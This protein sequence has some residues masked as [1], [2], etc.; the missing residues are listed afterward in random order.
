MAFKLSLVADVRQWLK[1]TQ[2][3]E[4]SI[5]DIADSLDDLAKETKADSDKA[6]DTLARDFKNA[7]DKVK[8]ESKQTGKKLGDNMKHGTKEAGEG[9]DD[10]KD[11]ANQSAKEAAA[12]FS[13]EFEDVSDYI[14][15]VLAQALAGFGPVGAAA[16]LAAAAGIGM[17]VSYL[18]N[19][20]EEAHAA[21]DR[22][23]DLSN[24]IKE[25]GG[26]MSLVDLTDRISE[27]L[28]KIID[29]KDWW[30]V[31]QT[32]DVTGAE[33]LLKLSQ[34][35]N[36]SLEDRQNIMR[37]EAGDVEASRRAWEMWNARLQEA[38]RTNQQF[39]DS[40]GNVHNSNQ[41][42]ID[43]LTK[44][45]DSQKQATAET[46]RGQ[47]AAKL[48]AEADDQQAKALQAAKEANDDFKNSLKDNATVLDEGLDKFKN[49]AGKID[50]AKILQEQA[51]RRKQNKII[52]KF[53]AEAELSDKAKANF[54]KFSPEEQ[55]QLAQDWN[56]GGKSRKKVKMVL[57]GDVSWEKTKV[58]EPAPINQPVQVDPNVKG[59]EEARNNAQAAMAA[60]PVVIQSRVDPPAMPAI[61]ATEPVVYKTKVDDSALPGM[62]TQARSKGQ[63][64]ADS[65]KIEYKTKLNTDGLQAAVNRAAAS[66]RTPT[67]YVNVKARKEV[68]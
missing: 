7:F 62:V 55:L 10:L 19:A 25:A 45:R 47:E 46:L 3:V 50:Y 60:N 63:R 38:W 51:N 61:P 13:G 35:Y 18:Q 44:N 32:G 42:L 5:D 20:E 23:I 66:I 16:G 58:P 26:D 52:L 53:D 14:Q 21:T 64:T 34:K 30:E 59:T 57:E 41:T 31:W 24:A 56:K 12:S 36:L 27:N 33:N 17:L 6:A 22:V 65:K 11:E 8:T 67:I 1:G 2:D 4:K 28:D 68:P 40:E 49:K 43:D 54:R 37:G 39:V 48:K 15:E 9:F 29:K